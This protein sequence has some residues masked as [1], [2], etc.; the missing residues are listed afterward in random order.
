LLQASK[1]IALAGFTWAWCGSA[2][3]ASQ[4][5]LRSPAPGLS[6]VSRH[7]DERSADDRWRPLGPCLVE[8]DR[9]TIFKQ[10]EPDPGAPPTERTVLRVMFDGQQFLFSVYAYDSEPDSSSFA[11]CRAMAR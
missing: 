11:R 7:T 10:R 1:A 2:L 4:L 9:H 6:R 8:G 5:R 3:P